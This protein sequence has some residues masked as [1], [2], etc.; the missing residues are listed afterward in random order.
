[1]SFNA[2]YEVIESYRSKPFEWGVADCCTFTADC[3]QTI[4]GID[5][6]ADYRGLYSNEAAALAL[7]DGSL[8]SR[9]N[10]LFEQVPLAYVGRGNVLMY[11]GALGVA[12]SGRYGFFMTEP[13]GLRAIPI[14]KCHYAWDASKCLPS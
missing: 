6:L 12:D 7:I 2:F 14:L 8:L 9:M 11:D 1:M 10:T 4:T 5:W 3:V 13:K